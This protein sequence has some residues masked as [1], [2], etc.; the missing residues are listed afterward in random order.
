MLDE[1][2]GSF[3]EWLKSTTNSTISDEPS[4]PVMDANQ[5]STLRV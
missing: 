3:I 5:F 2:L 4:A 1:S